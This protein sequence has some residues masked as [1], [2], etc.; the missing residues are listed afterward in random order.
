MH[1]ALNH[2]GRKQDAD[3]QIQESNQSKKGSK[4]ERTQ[5]LKE[6]LKLMYAVGLNHF[7]SHAS[8]VVQSIAADG[9]EQVFEQT[10]PYARQLVQ[11]R[12][13]GLRLLIEA[14]ILEG[15]ANQ[16]KKVD[17]GS[18][19]SGMSADNQSQ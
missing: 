3:Y 15:C 19:N 4:N 5:L 9:S 16:F 7:A 11:R 13:D 1:R 2:S 14:E 18:L 8:R 17:K 6:Q 10:P 12:A